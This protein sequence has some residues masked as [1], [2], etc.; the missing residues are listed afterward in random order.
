MIDV[1]GEKLV[2]N[3]PHRLALEAID[4]TQLTEKQILEVLEGKK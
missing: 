2:G 4:K 1:I 3:F